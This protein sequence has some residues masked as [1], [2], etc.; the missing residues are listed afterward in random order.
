VTVLPAEFMLAMEVSV[1]DQ[2]SARLV[3][4]RV[5]PSLNVPITAN[6][7]A[8]RFAREGFAGEIAIETRFERFTVKF[9]VLLLA[10]A[11]VAEMLLVPV[12][13]PAY[14]PS[15][16]ASPLLLVMNGGYEVHEA[17]LVT[18]CVE[19]SL[20]VAVAVNCC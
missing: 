20:K 1:N 17:R 3:T 10:P 18:S 14:N 6:V 7:I 11:N 19:L 12:L 2:F 13:C 5:L 4:S 16:M 8:V 9:A 15:P